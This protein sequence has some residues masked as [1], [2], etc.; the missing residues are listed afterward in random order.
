MWEARRVSRNL[1]APPSPWRHRHRLDDSVSTFMRVQR[2]CRVGRVVP[3]IS[4]LDQAPTPCCAYRPQCR[5][6]TAWE[7]GKREPVSMAPPRILEVPDLAFINN[8][9]TVHWEQ[10]G[11]ALTLTLR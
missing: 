4:S 5:S 6:P 11:S 9:K 8:M 2:C 3:G 1:T 7:P 10:A